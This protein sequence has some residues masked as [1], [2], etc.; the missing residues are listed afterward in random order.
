MLMAY[1][2]PYSSFIADLGGIDYG[3]VHLAMAT[4]AYTYQGYPLSIA[5]GLAGAVSSLPLITQTDLPATATWNL[6][7]GPA[8]CTNAGGLFNDNL[9]AIISYRDGSSSSGTPLFFAVICRGTD[10]GGGLAQITEDL[11][12][13]TQQSWVDV[14]NGTYTYGGSTNGLSL[15]NPASASAPSSPTGG[16]IAQGSA[17]ALIAVSNLVQFCEINS[18]SPT[19][20]AAA[21]LNLLNSY[22]GTPVIVTGHS[23]GGALTQVV[24]AYLNWQLGGLSPASPVIPQAFAPPTVGDSDFVTYYN[25]LFSS[26]GQFWVN[27]DDL[28]PCAFSQPALD[29][30]GYL[31]G[32]YQW[33]SNGGYGPTLFGYGSDVQH[34][35][36]LVEQEDLVKEVAKYIPA[37]AQ[38]AN[39]QLLSAN[40]TK[41][42][43]TQQQMQ[44]FLTN[45][46]SNSANWNSWT[47]VLMYQHLTPTYYA[48]VS[49]VSGVLSYPAVSAPVTPSS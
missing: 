28:V 29:D 1:A 39:P 40:S 14:L 43:P 48:L 49:A 15:Q 3:L 20:L 7:W 23:L 8:L 31:W 41:T 19:C 10:A 6:D 11:D 26:G 5:S 38:P 42:L 24:A 13:F 22:P 46:G 25:G 36:H 34:E 37:Y 18:G 17:D 33:P 35:E 27:Q 45:E 44:Q 16:V 32:K 47:S 9:V 12:A 2:P 21:L 4:I 30:A